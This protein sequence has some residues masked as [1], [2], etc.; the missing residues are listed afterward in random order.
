METKK[1]SIE[2]IQDLS[3]TIANLSK[4][5]ANLGQAINNLVFCNSIGDKRAD[6][7]KVDIEYIKWISLFLNERAKCVLDNTC[8]RDGLNQISEEELSAKLSY[9][10]FSKEN[11]VR[12]KLKAI[13]DGIRKAEADGKDRVE[14][15]KSNTN[16][17]DLIK[18]KVISLPLV[19]ES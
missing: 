16:V 12:N 7:I 11:E 10:F 3:K 19:P 6:N 5:S 15:L 17:D 1:S 18:D 9:A 4:A 14:W 13:C 2:T 8:G